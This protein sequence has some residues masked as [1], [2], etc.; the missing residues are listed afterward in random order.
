MEDRQLFEL[1][2]LLKQLVIKEVKDVRA[3]L[4]RF[5]DQMTRKIML[6]AA[7]QVKFE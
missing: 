1:I 4:T 6:N 7:P 3:T 2:P 5:R